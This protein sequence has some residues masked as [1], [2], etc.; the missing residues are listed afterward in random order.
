MR[1]FLITLFLLLT[2][3]S[4]AHRVRIPSRS[5]GFPANCARIAPVYFTALGTLEPG[6]V[7]SLAA[8]YQRVYHLDVQVLSPIPRINR[9]WNVER[10]QLDGDALVSTVTELHATTLPAHARIIAVTAEDQYIQSRPWRFALSVFSDHVAVISTA[11]MDPTFFREPADPELRNA[12]LHRMVTR[13]LGTLYCNFPRE[14]SSESVL[15]P[16]LL[17]VTDLDAIDESVW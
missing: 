13:L 11:R 10:Q 8:R 16:E 5:L 2:S 9:A 7:E 3:C 12:R 15:R 6:L 17:S 4:A 1:P 14:G